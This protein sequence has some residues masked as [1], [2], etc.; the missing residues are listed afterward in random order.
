MR[1]ITY[2]NS[3]NG[4]SA[5]FSS[6]NPLMHLD[7]KNFDGSSVGAT[8]VTYK[9]VEFDGQR[10]IST[11]LSARTIILPIQFTAKVNGR[12]SRAAALDKWTEILKTFVPLHSGT[13]TWTDGTKSRRIACR[14]LETPQITEIL[15]YLF[16][17]Q[18]QLVADYPYW[19]DVE[20]QSLILSMYNSTAEMSVNNTCG[21]PLPFCIDVP[22]GLS[23]WGIHGWLKGVKNI[24]TLA[25]HA[26]LE[27]PC[28]IDTKNCTVTAA[29]GTLVNNL[30][31]ADSSFFRIV[32]GTNV[33]LYMNTYTENDTAT[34][35]WRNLYMGVN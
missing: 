32:P 6:D 27:Q 13:L 26:A 34:L 28:T 12:Y 33:F 1:K 8:S 16:S 31:T 17:A 22:A 23:K 14:T 25:F 19:E 24:G 21:I 10:V 2:T 5:E 30:L 15:P 4:L 20:E 35:R 9:P 11:N 29:D 3:V 7:L 18:I